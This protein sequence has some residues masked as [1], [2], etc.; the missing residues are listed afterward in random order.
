MNIMSRLLD[1]IERRLGTKPLNLPSDISKDKWAKEV[2]ENETLDT[3]SRFFPHKI[4]Y[5]L[6]PEN[7]KNDMYLIDEDTCENQV[8]L[9]VGDIDWHDFSS[10]S[11]PF[12]INNIGSIILTD[13]SYDFEDICMTQMQ[14][15]HSSLFT[16]GIYI[17]WYPPNKVKLSTTLSNNYLNFMQNIPIALFVKHTPNLMTIEPT[18][19]ET[20][21][22]LAQADIATFLYQ[23]LKH[24]DG[25]DTVFATTDLKLASIEEEANKR[26]DIVQ[27]LEDNYVSA[28]NRNQPVFYTIN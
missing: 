24:Y 15:D 23:Y 3:F 2:I 16:S 14:A 12:G 11:P 4:P 18:K 9:A 5:F 20:F 10:K 27:K 1:K 8:I 22:K 21:E 6:T 25:I 19:M 17:D 26:E 28:A 13:T 7:K